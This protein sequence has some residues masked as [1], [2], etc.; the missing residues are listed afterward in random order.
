MQ[1]GFDVQSFRF[2]LTMILLSAGSLTVSINNYYD[3][4]LAIE[5]AQ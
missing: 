4:I 2:Q 3:S 5:P 1:E